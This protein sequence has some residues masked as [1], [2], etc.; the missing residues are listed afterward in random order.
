MRLEWT[1]VGVFST[2]VRQMLQSIR[3][4]VEMPAYILPISMGS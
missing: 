3:E 4:V 2:T 1:D